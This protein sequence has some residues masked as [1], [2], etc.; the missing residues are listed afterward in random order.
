MTIET[1][2]N[3]LY[4][5]L[6]ISI[7]FPLIA[8]IIIYKNKKLKKDLFKHDLASRHYEEMLYASK[9]GYLTYSIYKNKLYQYCSRRLATYLNLKNG[10]KSSIE[11]VFSAFLPKDKERLSSSFEA[12]SQKA[13]SFEIIIKSTNNRIFLANGVRINSSDAEINSNCIWFRDITTTSQYI[14]EKTNQADASRKSINDYRIL[15]DNIPTPIWLRDENL[16]ITLL[17]RPYLNLL[18]LKNFDELNKENSSLH[19]LGNATDF[20]SLAQNAKSTNTPQKKQVNILNN[21]DLRKYEITETPYHNSSLKTTHI[22][23]SL[24]DITNFDDAKRNYQMHL[25]S[26]LEILS[27][28]DTAFCIINQEHKIIFSNSAFIKLWNLPQNF[29]DLAPHYNLFLDKIRQQKTLPEVP[30]FKLYKEEENK[31]FEGLNEPREDLLY[32]PDGRTF[33]RIRAPHSDG[34][35]IAYED[36]TDDLATTRKLDDL[37]TVQ[38]AILNNIADSII[39]FQ[40][41]LKLKTCNTAYINLWKINPENL[42]S[43]LSLKDVLDIQKDYLPELDDWL[44]FREKMISHITS[45]TPFNLKLK[46]KKNL[47]VTPYVLPDTSLMLIYHKE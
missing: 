24:V 30:D 37:T 44:S 47:T 21:G 2:T 36:I 10:E 35:L 6:I 15:I 8:F 7:P 34:T 4:V 1:I 11:E 31:A 38:Q 18:G 33:K 42:S 5:W 27:T 20:K 26:H 16:N 3:L 22:V 17:N 40:P 45:M 29:T 12:L 9:D 23:G 13:I 25:D 28:L 46:N 39:I 43:Q 19:D 14:E 41:N 32:I